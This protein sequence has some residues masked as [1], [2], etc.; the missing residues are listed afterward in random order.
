MGRAAHAEPDARRHELRPARRARRP[1][2]AVP[3][4][5][6][7]GI[8]VPPRPAVEGP[9]RGAAGAVQRDPVRASGRRARRGLP[10][11]P[12]HGPAARVLQHRRAV[13]PVPLAAASRRVARPLAR[14]RGAARDRE[15]RDRARV[16]AT[17][18]GAGAGADRPYS[19]ARPRVHDVPLP[20]TGRDQRSDD[21]RHRP[22]VGD[23]GVQGDR[24]P[25]REA[26]GRGRRGGDRRTSP[27]AGR[28]RRRRRPQRRSRDRAN[29]DRSAESGSASN[30]PAPA[31]RRADRGR[32]SG[33]RR[34]P[35]RHHGVAQ[36]PRSRGNRRW[37]RHARWPR[38]PRRA[39]PAAADLEP[40]RRG[41]GGSARARSAT[42]ASG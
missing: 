8:S 21:R 25:G 34:V 28:E 17:R 36:R 15:R 24:D 40:C 12:D 16:L 10:D 5:G 33:G 3:D 29:G 18:G 22:E 9:G 4:R 42:S 39:A 6:S 7:P 32:A 20:R 13:E 14:G 38:G 2:V 19:A 41:S 26:A 23:G 37:A 35:G 31:A 27:R 30:G 11:P 1:A